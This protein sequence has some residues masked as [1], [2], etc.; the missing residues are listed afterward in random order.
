VIPGPFTTVVLRA[1]ITVRGRTARHPIVGT[2]TFKDGG[3]A[4][5]TDP[6]PTTGTA[7]FD[8]PAQGRGRH[9]IRVR[10]TGDAVLGPSDT[11]VA[12]P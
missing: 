6:D 11:H 5:A 7:V 10:Y 9:E 8:L 4:A 2:V 3:L 1:T 12:V